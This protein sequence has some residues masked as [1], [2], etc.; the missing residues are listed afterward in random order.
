M[1]SDSLD[2]DVMLYIVR[3]TWVLHVNRKLH[4]TE[5]NTCIPTYYYKLLPYYSTNDMFKNMICCVTTEEGPIG[6]ETFCC[7]NKEHCT[8]WIM[9]NQNSPLVS[10]LKTLVLLHIHSLYSKKADKMGLC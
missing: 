5:R 8:K 9:L 7:Q 1:S 2:E 10:S 6:A 4:Y 3:F